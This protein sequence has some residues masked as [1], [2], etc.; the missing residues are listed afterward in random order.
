MEGLEGFSEFFD[1]ADWNM[2]GGAAYSKLI[3]QM[4]AECSF[5]GALAG[6]VIASLDCGGQMTTQFE[7]IHGTAPIQADE[8]IARAAITVRRPLEEVQRAWREFEL[9]GT[10]E[11]TRGPGDLGGEI[12]AEL[13]EPVPAAASDL[14]A[15]YNGSSDSARLKS[16]LRALKARLET[17]E[18]P[19]VDG[20]PS[21]RD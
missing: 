5:A 15:R 17:G 14:L 19:T 20:Q 10:A 2:G 7:E 3:R 6:T 16:A 4:G 18:M 21:G 9:P 11:I 1:Y 8:G 12:R 13:T